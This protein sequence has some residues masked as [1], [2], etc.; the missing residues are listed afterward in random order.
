MLRVPDQPPNL[1][2]GKHWPLS[3]V[4]DPK[5]NIHQGF[6]QIFEGVFDTQLATGP[7][8]PR[9]VM[10][11]ADLVLKRNMDVLYLGLLNQ[12]KHWINTVIYPVEVTNDTSFRQQRITFFNSPLVNNPAMGTNDTI[13]DMVSTVEVGSKRYGKNFMMEYEH[14]GTVQG[15]QR[16]M[17]MML[18]INGIYIQHMAFLAYYEL[19]KPGRGE[20]ESRKFACSDLPSLARHVE[21]EVNESFLLY[22]ERDTGI[23]DLIYPYDDAVKRKLN[24]QR[25]QYGIM[26]GN[27]KQLFITGGNKYNYD[28]SK[29]GQ[30]AVDRLKSGLVSNIAGIDFHE[31]PTMADEEDNARFDALEDAR[32]FGNYYTFSANTDTPGANIPLNYQFSSIYDA[33]KD[34]NVVIT[35]RKLMPGFKDLLSL[36]GVNITF[37][38]DDVNAVGLDDEAIYMQFV[39][40]IEFQFKPQLQSESFAPGATAPQAPRSKLPWWVTKIHRVDGY[41]RIYSLGFGGRVNGRATTN[42]PINLTEFFT[43]FNVIGLRPLETLATQ[44]L[45]LC[46]ANVG[47]TA[48]SDA[49]YLVGTSA[50]NKTVFY[51]FTAWIAVVTENGDKIV[52]IPNAF[53]NGIIGGCN[54][55]PVEPSQFNQ[56]C[57][58]GFKIDEENYNTNSMYMMFVDK[59]EDVQDD[60]IIIRA[61]TPFR[62]GVP[63]TSVI[64]TMPMWNRF[65]KFGE[66]HSNHDNTN[67][68]NTVSSFCFRGQQYDVHGDK[69]KMISGKTHHGRFE[70]PGCRDVRMFGK[71]VYPESQFK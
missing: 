17:R 2:G 60:W 65:F 22:K 62:N 58:E 38:H 64:S 71:K 54:T 6:D 25:L 4:S 3:S 29:G 49:G 47:F 32:R 39:E 57:E 45:T 23:Y 27:K 66:A 1:H 10:V 68:M 70:F 33:E 31:A 35:P 19:K 55:N 59:T 14:L 43:L 48:T 11:K 18:Q 30:E 28:Y 56:Y 52:N 37:E 53:Y 63:N 44:T 20:Y 34:D 15:K 46:T 69:G 21:A 41:V 50:M 24:G 42:D 26:P 36:N 61:V 9:S 51:N 12:Q 67:G 7:Q 16:V 5:M 13:Q 40:A 8:V